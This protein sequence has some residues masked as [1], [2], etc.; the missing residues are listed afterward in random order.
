MGVLSQGRKAFGSAAAPSLVL[1]SALVVKVRHEGSCGVGADVRVANRAANC[2][3]EVGHR[4]NGRQSV[5][6]V[7][8]PAHLTW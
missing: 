5:F 1:A 8:V 4:V 7:V 3:V 6:G 2:L